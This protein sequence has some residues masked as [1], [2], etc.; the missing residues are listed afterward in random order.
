[1]V[2]SWP[3]SKVKWN[4]RICEKTSHILWK[5]SG[6]KQRTCPLVFW[7]LDWLRGGIWLSKCIISSAVRMSPSVKLGL[8]QASVLRCDAL[9]KLQAMI[10]SSYDYSG[11]KKVLS[12]ARTVRNM[13]SEGNKFVCSNLKEVK[14]RKKTIYKSGMRMRELQYCLPFQVNN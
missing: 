12:K 10:L 14:G 7:T 11:K 3:G 6:W 13:I 4:E 9:G 8:R 2:W 5:E 1:M